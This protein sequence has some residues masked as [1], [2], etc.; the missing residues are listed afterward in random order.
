MVL[1]SPRAGALELRARGAGWKKRGTRGTRTIVRIRMRTARAG[2]LNEHFTDRTY[3]DLYYN[4]VYT[5]I[6]R[7]IR[8]GEL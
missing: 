7:L 5:A 8:N 3:I 4:A 6:D 2:E 1:S